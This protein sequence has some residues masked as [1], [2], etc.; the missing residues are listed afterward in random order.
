MKNLIILAPVL[1]MLVGYVYHR[2]SDYNAEVTTVSDCV[3]QKWQDWESVRGVMPTQEEENM[4]REECW[5][6]MGATLNQGR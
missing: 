2:Q 5:A 3:I 6:D 4:F 1:T